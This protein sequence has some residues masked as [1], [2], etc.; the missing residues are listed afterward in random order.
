MLVPSRPQT[1]G[2]GTRWEVD[3]DDWEQVSRQIRVRL[4][5]TAR[6]Q[7]YITYGKLVDGI[8]EIAGPHSHAL[9]AMLGE[10][11]TDCHAE[12]LPLPSALVLYGDAMEPGPGFFKL[13]E[14]L[15]VDLGSNELAPW[16]FWM[17]N[18][19]GAHEHWAP[20]GRPA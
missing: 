17:R 19:K 5:K 4:Q 16:E 1:T 3:E 14:S 13:A 10:I 8:P 12:G 18:L 6:D 15:G 2:V 20:G 9:A 7:T 11:S